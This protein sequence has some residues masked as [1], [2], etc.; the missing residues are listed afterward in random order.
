MDIEMV[1][2]ETFQT[3]CMVL[4]LPQLWIVGYRPKGSW[5]RGSPYILFQKSLGWWNHSICQDTTLAQLVAWINSI[6]GKVHQPP[7]K[8]F[9][10][11]NV[12]ISSTKNPTNPATYS[13]QPLGFPSW[14]PWFDSSRY[15]FGGW[16][17]VVTPWL[18]IL[19]KV[20]LFD[21]SEILLT[22]WYM[23]NIYHYF[24]QGFIHVRWLFG[25][26]NHQQ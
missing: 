20:L 11:K 24:F 21:G 2:L 14:K 23:V 25:I 3:M 9:F 22:S 26:L 12:G 15:L 1:P 8:E 16:G 4:P 19:F 10:G 7:S 17:L 6:H 13:W 5:G 18:G